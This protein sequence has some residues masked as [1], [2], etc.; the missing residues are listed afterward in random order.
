MKNISKPAVT[1]A[2]KASVT[3]FGTCRLL[4]VHSSNNINELINY[5]HSTKEVI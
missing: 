4:K 5:T 1:V 3:L 2:K